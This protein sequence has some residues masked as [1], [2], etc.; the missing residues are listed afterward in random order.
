MDHINIF[1]WTI[2]KVFT[3]FV[4]VLLLFYVLFIG[5]KAC[6]IFA[7][8]FLVFYTIASVG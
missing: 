5:L 7:L 4:T 3:E 6:G 1:L 2:F 8:C